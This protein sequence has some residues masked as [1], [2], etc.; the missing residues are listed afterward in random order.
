ML[1]YQK[2]LSKKESFLTLSSIIAMPDIDIREDLLHYVWK[3][4][5][6]HLEPLSTHDGQP[7]EIVT[8]GIHNHDAGPDF[9]SC[10]I[11]IDNTLWA[12]HV[13]MHIRASDWVRHG[14]HKDPAYDNVVLHV[15]LHY[16]AAIQNSKGEH[17]PTLVLNNRIDQKLISNYDILLKSDST[18]PCERVIQD[19]HSLSMTMWKERLI[20]ERLEAKSVYIKSLLQANTHDWET[21]FYI[22]LARYMG[23]RVNTNAFEALACSL[24]LSVLLKNRDDLTKIECLLFGNAGFLDDNSIDDAYHKK[25]K[26]EYL[27]LKSKYTLTPLLLSSWRFL[28]MRP[29]G[30]PTVRIAQLAGILYNNTSLFS[31]ILEAEKYDDYHQLFQSEASEYWDDHYRF[32]KKSDTK[33]KKRLTPAFIDLLLIN[34]VCPVLFLYGIEKGLDIYRERAISLLCKIKPEKNTIISHWNTVGMSADNA[35]DSQSLLQLRKE[36]CDKKRCLECSIGNRIVKII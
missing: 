34:V 11:K 22:V 2:G 8:W 28:R 9:H 16:D 1:I 20:A 24:P 33:R 15:V 35:M 4:K 21:T 17:I 36:Y 10:Q 13:E 29:A 25:L 30:F 6:V 32:G 23:A 14:H 5:Q 18:I 3:T 7:I 26:T 27:F 19:V 12:G 31:K